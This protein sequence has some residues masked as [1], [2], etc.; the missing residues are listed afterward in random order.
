MGQGLRGSPSCQGCCRQL[1][2]LPLTLLG[3]PHQAGTVPTIPVSMGKPRPRLVS[4]CRGSLLV[5][6][7]S[8]LQAAAAHWSLTAGR[9]E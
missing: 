4:Q 2:V 6:I 5:N 3:Q 1:A 9:G 8:G 7:A